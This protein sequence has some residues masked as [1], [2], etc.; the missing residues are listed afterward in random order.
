MDI[1]KRKEKKIL[2]DAKYYVTNGSNE[3][4]LF[5]SCN[6]I[7]RGQRKQNKNRT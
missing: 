5:I 6:S 7:C 3:T 2:T 4:D 1:D